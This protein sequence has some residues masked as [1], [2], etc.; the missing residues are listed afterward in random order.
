M[1][2]FITKTVKASQRPKSECF[3]WVSDMKY[4]LKF[5]LAYVP[6]LSLFGFRAFGLGR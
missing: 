2:P 6:I 5:E 4:H 3:V 1:T